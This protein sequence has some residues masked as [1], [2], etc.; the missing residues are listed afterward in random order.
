MAGK[1]ISMVSPGGHTDVPTQRFQTEANGLSVGITGGVFYKWKTNGSPYVVPCV[2]GDHTIGTDTA[3]V[4][5]AASNSTATTAAD[6][7]VDLYMPLP[8][9]IYRAYGTIAANVAA[10]LVGDRVTID[11]SATT[12]A[13][14]W[15]I[16]ESAGEGQTNAF[17][18]V[19]VN[20]VEDTVDFILRFGATY[21]GDQDLA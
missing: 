17:C 1:R 4:G 15:T 14:N 11:V 12:D 9:V 7:T 5:L 18:I 20:A 3:I 13:G 19:G 16:N 6:G 10:T 2:T 8:G 21:L